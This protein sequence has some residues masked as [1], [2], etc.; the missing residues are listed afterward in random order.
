MP[1]RPDGRGIR[2]LGLDGAARPGL[3]VALAAFVVGV[4]AAFGDQWLRRLALGGVARLLDDVVDL[5]LGVGHALVAG[6]RVLDQIRLGLLLPLR[7]ALSGL[8]EWA[9]SL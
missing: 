6:R 2:L 8:G 1:Q 4:A 9:L 3:P 7:L 5:T